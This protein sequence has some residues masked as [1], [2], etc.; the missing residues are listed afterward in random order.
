MPT[1]E[2]GKEEQSFVTEG[3]IKERMYKAR[4]NYRRDQD[5]EYE[6]LRREVPVLKAEI[7][8]LK[9]LLQSHG[10]NCEEGS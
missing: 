10:I 7:A 5:I 8:R 4:T 3:G 6:R 2:E 9:K 1:C